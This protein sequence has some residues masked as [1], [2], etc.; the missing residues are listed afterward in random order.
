VYSDITERKKAEDE[1]RS[2][3][4]RFKHIFNGASDAIFVV[5]PSHERIIDA[6]TVAHTMLEY[7]RKE[8]LELSMVDVHPYEMRA[9]KKFAEEVFQHGEGR[10]DQ[11]SC[12]S[13]SGEHIP[14]EMAAT[15]VEM[16]GQACMLVVARDI[17]ERKRAEEIML[18]AKE[19]AELATRAKTE[20]LA[21]MSHELRTPLNAII[22]FSEI[23]TTGLLG[24]IGSDKY[25]EYAHDIQSSGLHLLELIN[26]ILD[27]SKI[28]AD[29]A[30]LH[31]E[32]VD[33]ARIITACS[34]L[35]KDRASTANVNLEE[36]IAEGLPTLRADE[37]KLKQ[38][39]LNLLSNAVKFTEAGGFVT[40]RAT[41]ATDRRLV[42]EVRDTG[43]GIA[44]EDIAAAMTPFGQ[45]DGRLSRKYEGTGLGLPLTKSLVELHGGIL[46][47]ESEMG[48]GTVAKVL[49]PA[50]RTHDEASDIKPLS[51][52]AGGASHRR[53]LP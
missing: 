32:I 14:V 13:K 47:I 45:L 43:I 6:N 36:Q 15:R 24:P 30:E 7:S 40:V 19:Q 48:K 34:V 25:R 21:N 51:V 3:Q 38:I 17:T 22:G 49:F 33:V 31:E 8:L 16:Q 12:R 42:I 2:S 52:A 26:D 37:R 4:E 27:L 9:L 23:M 46:E 11:L 39:V 5:D 35:V 1:L 18:A 50:E 29:K 10:T 28:E 53:E 41:L 20:F 44:P